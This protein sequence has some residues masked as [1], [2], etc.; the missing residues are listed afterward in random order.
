[1]T[2]KKRRKRKRI[3]QSRVRAAATH[4]IQRARERYGVEMSRYDYED[5]VRMIKNGES[6]FVRKQSNTRLLHWVVVKGVRMLAVYFPPGKAAH[7]GLIRTFAP[8]EL[9]EEVFYAEGRN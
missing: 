7:D 8:P 6:K 4:A 2:T 1:M 9:A 5:A 3:T